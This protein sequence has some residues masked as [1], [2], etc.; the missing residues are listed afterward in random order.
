M[1]PI[2][3]KSQ[4]VPNKTFRIL[5]DKPLAYWIVDTLQ[6]IHLYDLDIWI[7]TDS[8]KVIELYEEGGYNLNYYLRPDDVR[9]HDV[10]MNTIIDDWM[11][12]CNV[13]Y[14]YYLQVHITNPF[15]SKDLLQ[16]AIGNIDHYSQSSHR[17]VMG[18]TRH[19]CRMWYKGLPVNFR[20]GEIK[21]TQDLCPVYEDNSCFY[22]F[23]YTGF[24]LDGRVS[25]NPY[26]IEVPFPQNVDID[27]EEDWKLAVAIAQSLLD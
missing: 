2:K 11:I 17:S 19:Q 1:I 12:G 7:N 3:E 14:P 9:G 26:M 27:T 4:R 8:T 18:V 20:R 15:V 25:S 10:S 23:D 21:Q 6:G 22:A 5:G 24:M 13:N 16:Q